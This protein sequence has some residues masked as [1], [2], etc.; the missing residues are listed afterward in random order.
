[1][2]D[3]LR[4]REQLGLDEP[5][6]PEE[7]GGASR[8][9]VDGMPTH[10]LSTLAQRRREYEDLSARYRSLEANSKRTHEKLGEANRA[11]RDLRGAM[12]SR[13]KDHQAAQRKIET[14][15]KN[16]AVVEWLVEYD[17]TCGYRHT[18]LVPRVHEITGMT[19]L[20]KALHLASA[21]EG[22]RR[23][24]AERHLLCTMP[25]A[26][27]LP[28]RSRATRR[29]MGASSMRRERSSTT[30]TRRSLRRFSAGMRQSS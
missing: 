5:R 11:L 30:R 3:A 18:P 17:R 2:S 20:W 8:P 16:L 28:T 10:M 26:D 23:A 15:S 24:A 25:P 27:R 29:R 7:A 12:E 19:A 9:L 4:V 14:L 13:E 21:P 22:V 6:Q 1:M